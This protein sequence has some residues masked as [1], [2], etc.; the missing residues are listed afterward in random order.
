MINNRQQFFIKVK[1]ANL[2]DLNY[3]Y[4]LEDLKCLIN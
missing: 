3:S 1:Y 4:N 2:D